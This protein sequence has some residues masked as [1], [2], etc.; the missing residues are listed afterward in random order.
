MPGLCDKSVTIRGELEEAAGQFVTCRYDRR[1][2]CPDHRESKRRCRRPVATQR[3]RSAS[4]VARARRADAARKPRRSVR[5]DPLRVGLHGPRPHVTA[6][7][8]R[9]L[10]AKLVRANVEFIVVGG[11][12]V[13]AWGH[14][15][16]TRDLD[17]VP[18][19]SS[20]NLERLGAVLRE[21]DGRVETPD[22]RLGPGAI[23]TFLA[24]GDRVLVGTSLGP[25]DVLQGL[26]QVPRYD[27]LVSD[28]VDV[29][30]GDLS[31]RVCSLEALLAMKRTAGR[32]SDVADVDALSIA[33]GLDPSATDL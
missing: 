33:N 30:L 23:A 20:T 10:I 2:T 22:G 11:L 25:V 6:L 18:D 15:R 31:I 16:T 17:I 3:D 29:D 24:A 13:N 32:P 1:Q 12:A 4:A 27:D 14:I 21:L 8:L 7:D 19:P 5:I 26:P 28:A 9:E